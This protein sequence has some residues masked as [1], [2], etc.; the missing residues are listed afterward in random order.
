MRSAA[1]DISS[2][3]PLPSRL[4]CSTTSR[5]ISC[6]ERSCAR[7]EKSTE[8][9]YVTA[10]SS[11]STAS[12]GP[13]SQASSLD[14]SSGSVRRIVGIH[15]VAHATDSPDVATQGLELLAD[16]VDIDLD[17]IGAHLVAPSVQVVH[18]VL[19]ADHAALAQQQQL[20]HGQFAHRQIDLLVVTEHAA[21]DRVQ[22]Q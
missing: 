14:C 18:H 21:A 9:Q 15:Q 3:R 20:Q 2:F 22:P 16:P 13:S 12:S 19:L 1:G 11:T 10:V 6:S 7:L 5:A 8:V 4:T 17:G